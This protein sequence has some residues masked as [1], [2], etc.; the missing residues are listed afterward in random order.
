MS[1]VTEILQLRRN[2]IIKQRFQEKILKIRIK[3]LI[4][5]LNSIFVYKI[6][7]IPSQYFLSFHS[8]LPK[9]EENETNNSNP[10]RLH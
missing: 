7:I 6:K 9:N 5:E 3:F 1:Y 4:S 8:F 2:A 10:R